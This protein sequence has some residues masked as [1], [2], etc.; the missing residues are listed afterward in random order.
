M[1]DLLSDPERLLSGKL[2]VHLKYLGTAEPKGPGLDRVRGLLLRSGYMSS[3]NGK[4]GSGSANFNDCVQVQ[5]AVFGT[6]IP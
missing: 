4:G 1:A 2:F 3:S 5:N 6:E